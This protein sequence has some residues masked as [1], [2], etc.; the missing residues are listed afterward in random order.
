MESIERWCSFIN[1]HIGLC[2]ISTSVPYTVF[3]PPQKKKTLSSC[4][5][6]QHAFSS[7]TY[8]ASFIAPTSTINA[9]GDVI[10]RNKTAATT[11]S[12]L[13]LGPPL[14]VYQSWA[15]GYSLSNFRLKYIVVDSVTAVSELIECT[16]PPTLHPPNT[17]REVVWLLME[18]LYHSEYRFWF[19]WRPFDAGA[20]CP[21]AWCRNVARCCLCLCDR[22]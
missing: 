13:G 20:D 8:G 22:L 11:A 3:A 21:D 6:S 7:K 18:R 1:R 2:F 12:L 9:L 10:C 15:S 17:S 5:S 19:D 14:P 4:W 16:P